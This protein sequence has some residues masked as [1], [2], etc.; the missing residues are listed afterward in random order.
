MDEKTQTIT[1][2][3]DLPLSEDVVGRLERLMRSVEVGSDKVV[4]SPLSRDKSPEDIL[5]GWDRLFNQ[6]RSDLV[7]TL[8]EMEESNR[9]KF[10]PRSR[11]K[12]W[13]ERRDSVYSYFRDG[14]GKSLVEPGDQTRKAGGI[15]MTPKSVG[16]TID[17]MVLS[18]SSGLPFLTVK[19]D[20]LDATV[21]DLD[22][23]LSR[24][25]PCVLFTRTQEDWK[26]R[27]VWGYPFADT[28]LEQQ[29]YQV[30]LPWRKKLVQRA[31]LAGPD[32]VER[33]VTRLIRSCKDDWLLSIDFSAYDASLQ[34]RLCVP[35]LGRLLR[36]FPDSERKRWIIERFASIGIVT[37][38]GVVS[39]LHGVPSG[40]S[41]TNEVDS[42]VQLMIAALLYGG[43]QDWEDVVNFPCTV[44]GDD[45]V[46]CTADPESLMSH[47]REYGLS[48]N[49][50]KSH[51]A[52]NEVICLQNLYN[53]KYTFGSV[54]GGVYPTYRALN[55]IIYP[56]RWVELTKRDSRGSDYFALRTISILEN[57]KRHPMFVDFVSYVASLDRDL[58]RFTSTG[59]AS[60]IATEE[61][62][63]K[64]SPQHHWG[65]HLRGI[66]RFETMRVLKELRG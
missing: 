29:F 12:K 45:G 3:R 31:A 48:V 43:T 56:E 54:I 35:A 41:F 23:L 2:I 38:D 1:N 53:P 57:C 49:E 11:A 58:L 42:E 60:E 33:E 39:G 22:D 8:E 19:R 62:K 20:V 36:K 44:Q 18:T 26:T 55:R 61:S 25:D 50:D 9:S 52:R 66:H 14:G 32:A 47:F 30:V 34:P 63:G 24:R 46:Y 37:P 17:E 64:G 4:R 13:S 16:Q 59:L 40:S 10:G 15:Y 7:P 6:R 28:I 65:D 51:V 5:A 21:K 27:T